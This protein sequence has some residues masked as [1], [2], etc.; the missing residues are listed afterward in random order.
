VNPADPRIIG[1][2]AFTN[3]F[4]N[5]IFLTSDGGDTWIEAGIVPASA[6]DYNAKFSRNDLYCVTLRASWE[7]VDRW[8]YFNPPTRVPYCQWL[9]STLSLKSD[10]PWV[11]VETVAKG[12]TRARIASTQPIPIECCDF[13]GH[14]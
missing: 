4:P 11:V 14:N 2:T 13:G 1:G 10:Q 12:L 8:P 3:Q 6:F 5:V 9:R 7:L